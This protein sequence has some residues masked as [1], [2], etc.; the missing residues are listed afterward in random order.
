MWVRY[1]KLQTSLMVK[2]IFLYRKV[3]VQKSI[4][5]KYNAQ[6]SRTFYLK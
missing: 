5:V 4:I 2:E 6:K 3:T 1:V